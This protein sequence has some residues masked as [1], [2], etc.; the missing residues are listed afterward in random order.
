MNQTTKEINKVTGTVISVAWKLIVIALVIMI[1]FEGITKGYQF[2]YSI[3][4]DTAAADP[5]GIDMRVTIGEDETLT[6]I[7]SA[8][9]EGG[10]IKDKYIFLIQSIFYEYG[11]R[12][13]DIIPG[14]YLLNNSMSGKDIVVALRD[15]V[16]EE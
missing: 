7:A 9:E 14:T 16:V 10:L 2:G 6:D 11:V 15:G 13:N 5:P 12:G 3:F 8:L 4:Y 1:L